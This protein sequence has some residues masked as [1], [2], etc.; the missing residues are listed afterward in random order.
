MFA[1]RVLIAENEIHLV[2]SVERGFA[3]VEQALNALGEDSLGSARLS[4]V[5]NGK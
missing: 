5:E 1:L 3:S 4:K 2:V